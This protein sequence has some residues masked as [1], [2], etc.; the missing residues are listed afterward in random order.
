MLLYFQME[1]WGVE[2]YCVSLRVKFWGA[3]CVSLKGR[4]DI[5]V[6]EAYVAR[7]ALQISMEAGLDRLILI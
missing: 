2:E 7:H 1:D 6:A 5:D 4:F 3:T